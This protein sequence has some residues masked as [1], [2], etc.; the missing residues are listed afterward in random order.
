MMT[1]K[2]FTDYFI[3]T[4]LTILTIQTVGHSH[5]SC[6]RPFTCSIDTVSVHV[7]KATVH[8]ESNQWQTFK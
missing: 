1:A 8:N 4:S 2:W 6:M 3:L 5:L 7:L